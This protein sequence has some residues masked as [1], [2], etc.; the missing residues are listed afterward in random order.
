MANP[1]PPPWNPPESSRNRDFSDSMGGGV[2]GS[3]TD[4]RQYSEGLRRAAED[5]PL[6]AERG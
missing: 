5:L 4:V 3:A 2:G 1:P 6:V